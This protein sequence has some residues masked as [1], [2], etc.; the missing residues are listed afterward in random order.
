MGL[1]EEA[2]GECPAAPKV[3]PFLL[4]LIPFESRPPP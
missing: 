1:L 4:T 3:G 2:L